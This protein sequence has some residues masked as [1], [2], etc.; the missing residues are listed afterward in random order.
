MHSVFG[1]DEPPGAAVNPRAHAS[2]YNGAVRRHQAGS[3]P[4]TSQPLNLAG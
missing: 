4:M 2:T 3:K 1:G